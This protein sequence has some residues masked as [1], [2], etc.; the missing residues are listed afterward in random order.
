MVNISM[1]PS[2]NCAGALDSRAELTGA[3]T[4]SA[5]HRVTTPRQTFF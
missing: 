3:V 2:I 4:N 1:P 5:R